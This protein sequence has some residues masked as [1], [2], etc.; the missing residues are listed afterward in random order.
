MSSQ[1]RSE[2]RFPSGDSDI[3]AWHYPGTNGVCVVMAAGLGVT[4]GA[5][6]DTF[7]ARFAEEGFSV[8]AFDY[9]RL[10]TSG[11]Y[12]RQIINIDE[13]LADWQAAL[14][15]A[16]KLPAVDPARIAIWGF[17]VSAGHV[18]RVASK[19][20]ELGA[21]IAQGPMADGLAAARYASGH[22]PL[23]DGLKR[24]LWAALDAIGGRLGRE[25]LLVPLAGPPGTL[26]ALNTPDSRN[27]TQALN[28]NGAYDDEWRQ[29]IAARSAMAPAFYRPGLDAKKIECPLLVIVFDQDGVTPPEQARRAAEAA[30]R[31]EKLE[32]SGG[33]YA[34]YG[35]AFEQTVEGEISFLTRHL[36]DGESSAGAAR[37]GSGPVKEQQPAI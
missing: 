27:G 35:E 3:S 31:G 13:Q 2:V 26:A 5:G 18:F 29:E 7:A 10:G 8:L 1:Q 32:F 14:A 24:T 33:H 6:T 20:P 30:P 11:G 12:P 17:S 36:L 34:P 4:K 19:E 22:E 23:T 25:P 28:G 21:A 15:Y 37:N 16:R 9:R